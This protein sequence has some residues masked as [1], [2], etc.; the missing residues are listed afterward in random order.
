[1]NEEFTLNEIE[2]RFLIKEFDEPRALLALS[3][4]SIS[5]PPLRNE[6]YYGYRLYEQ[7][8]DQARN[9]L[10]SPLAFNINRE[11]KIVRLSAL[12]NPS[13]YGN[14]FVS[15]YGTDK[16]FKDQLPALRAV[17]NFIEN[18]ISKQDVFFLERKNY[19]VK[20]ITY[21]WTLND[22]SSPMGNE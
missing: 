6:P 17:L 22:S 2:Q 18:Y 7:L 21:N 19:S 5:G 1:M 20:Y 11:D 8:D 4:A 9:F 13:W 14:Y 16:K 15:K 12:F 3:R 10:S